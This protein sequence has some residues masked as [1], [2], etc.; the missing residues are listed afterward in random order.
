MA[1]GFQV[2]LVGMKNS[3]R[4]LVV[5]G[6]RGDDPHVVG[7]LGAPI[8]SALSRQEEFELRHS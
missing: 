7:Y 8:L 6:E 1:G 2:S 3:G 4:W 5:S